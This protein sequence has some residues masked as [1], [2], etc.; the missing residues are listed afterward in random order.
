MTRQSVVNDLP[1]G[2]WHHKLWGQWDILA[3]NAQK[4]G[5]YLETEVRHSNQSHCWLPWDFYLVHKPWYC[6]SFR[7]RQ[8]LIIVPVRAVSRPDERRR[9]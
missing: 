4:M 7:Y 5:E 3:M 6:L 8:W 1:T 9:L 2:A